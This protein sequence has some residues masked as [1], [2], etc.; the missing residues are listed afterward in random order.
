MNNSIREFL[1][2]PERNTDPRW[3]VRVP[4][5]Q[6]NAKVD[7]CLFFVDDV[8]I[9]EGSGFFVIKGIKF[10]KAHH[11]LQQEILDAFD[12]TTVFVTDAAVT[13]FNPNTWEPPVGLVCPDEMTGSL[14]AAYLD[15]Q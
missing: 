6:K 5:R 1:R 4:L 3:R 15:A 2:S 7:D 9:L 14:V 11:E 8:S 10:W 13:G 12:F